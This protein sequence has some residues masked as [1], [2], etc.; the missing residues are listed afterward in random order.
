[1]STKVKNNKLFDDS[2][3]V[4]I[5]TANG[6]GSISIVRLSGAS[7]LDIASKISKKTQFQPRLATLAS[8]YSIED[9]LIDRLI[10]AVT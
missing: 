10:P 4:A 6:I 5:A 9:E 8:L 3:I 2:T 1:M 7:A